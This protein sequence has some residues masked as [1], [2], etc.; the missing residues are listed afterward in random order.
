[1]DILKP[2]KTVLEG[3]EPT[4]QDGLVWFYF[5]LF[6]SRFIYMWTLMALGLGVLFFKGSIS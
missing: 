4:L 5:F 3:K 2:N 6:N 1:M